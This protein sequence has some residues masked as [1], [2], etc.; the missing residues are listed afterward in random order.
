MSKAFANVRS[1]RIAFDS[2][3]D[4]TSPYFFSFVRPG[5][6]AGMGL[7]VDRKQVR[8]IRRRRRC[9]R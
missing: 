2:R 3:K 9:R 1:L 7:P 4:K 6:L 5:R 8:L